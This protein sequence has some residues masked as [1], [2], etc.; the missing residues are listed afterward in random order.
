MNYYEW[1]V[2]S[3]YGEE[4]VSKFGGWD[5]VDPTLI[6]VGMVQLFRSSRMK[7]DQ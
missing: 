6:P 7:L 5:A 2:M 3:L 1:W 4:V